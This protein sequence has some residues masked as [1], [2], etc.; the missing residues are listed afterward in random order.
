MGEG[1]DGGAPVGFGAKG[2]LV[3]I[4]GEGNTGYQGVVAASPTVTPILYGSTAPD[5]ATVATTA[6]VSA[7]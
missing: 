3:Q 7:S 2:G 5:S 4:A 1:S 6:T